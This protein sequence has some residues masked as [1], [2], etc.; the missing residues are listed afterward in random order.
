MGS[1]EAAL[2]IESSNLI[3]RW[4][5]FASSE[6]LSSRT[7]KGPVLIA[8]RQTILIMFA[9]QTTLILVLWRVASA[10]T[11]DSVPS[12]LT[13]PSTNVQYAPLG[14]YGDYSLYKL[15][16]PSNSTFTQISRVNTLLEKYLQESF[17]TP[18]RS[19]PNIIDFCGTTILASFLRNNTRRSLE[20]ITGLLLARL[21]AYDN[22]QYICYISVSSQHRQ[23]GLGTK[24]MQEMINQA[25]R[26]RNSRVTLHVNTANQSALSLYLRCGMRCVT[27]IPGFY[28]GD[29]TYATQNAFFMLVQLANVKNS[30]Q[31]CQAAGAVE[32][33]PQEEATYQQRCS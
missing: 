3:D 9:V 31:V 6:G 2:G 5:I 11:L 17:D 1:A 13:D 18:S 24:L 22:S 29:Q 16:V 15:H 26:T 12:R 20:N 7:E 14:D 32:I 21:E 23:K 4:M 28:F 25:I 10:L 33:P 19:Y 8:K 27:S 30:T